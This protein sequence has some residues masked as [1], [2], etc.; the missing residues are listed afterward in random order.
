ML[1]FGWWE[2]PSH[3]PLPRAS[4]LPSLAAAALEARGAF[5]EAALAEAEAYAAEDYIT[6]LLAE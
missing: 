2:Q 6:D 1:D 3:S 5:S 4:L